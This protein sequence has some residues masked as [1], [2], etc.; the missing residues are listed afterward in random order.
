MTELI[1]IILASPGN[2]REFE[3]FCGRESSRTVEGTWREEQ[4]TC[5]DLSRGV[6]KVDRE[7]SDS[8]GISGG[9]VNVR[10]EYLRDGSGRIPQLASSIQ[11]H[12]WA[13]ENEE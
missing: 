8:R 1:H 5:L 13:I 6:W 12:G 2:R 9:Q 10:P 7:Q 11:G 3:F 4:A